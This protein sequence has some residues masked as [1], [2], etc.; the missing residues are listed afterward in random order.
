MPLATSKI[1]GCPRILGVGKL[2][3]IGQVNHDECIILTALCIRFD[4]RQQLV[5]ADGDD[6]RRKTGC[7]F[8]Q[9]PADF[10][11]LSRLGDT[12]CRNWPELAHGV[13]PVLSWYRLQ[14]ET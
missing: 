9:I 12:D 6:S 1:L 5:A 7:L 8:R 14:L 13:H 10:R 4:V 3:E 11:G 2:A